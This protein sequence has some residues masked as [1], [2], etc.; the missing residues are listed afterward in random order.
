MAADSFIYKRLITR[1]NNLYKNKGVMNAML[2]RKR[3]V[4][5]LLIFFYIFISSQEIVLAVAQQL[6]PIRVDN[7]FVEYTVN[8]GNGRFSIK[9]V[10][11]TAEGK[12]S[13]SLRDY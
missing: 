6:T 3:M 12:D 13:D 10:K 9:T 7:G 5:A 2:K 11:G 1:R 4:A 8:P